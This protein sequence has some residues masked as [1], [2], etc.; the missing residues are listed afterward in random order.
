MNKLIFGL[1]FFVTIINYSQNNSKVIVPEN[2]KRE[3]KIII[4]S[5]QKFRTY[6][7]KNR[8]NLLKAEID[9][10]WRLQSIEDNRNT[11]RVIEI[12]EEYGY[13]LSSNSN[14]RFPMHIILMHTP[15]Q[16]KDTVY[17]VIN[18]E[19]EAGRITQSSYGMITWHLDGRKEIKLEQFLNQ[20]D[21]INK[22]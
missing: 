9:S 19:M 3:L 1:L 7:S 12:I 2:I 5:D 10:L 16:L 4:E 13:L 20:N 8:K 11:R 17:K 6:I 14:T 18:M 21:S 15:N 22:Q